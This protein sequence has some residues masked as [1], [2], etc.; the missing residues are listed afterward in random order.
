MPP[1]L[2]SFIP[3][4]IRWRI[5]ALIDRPELCLATARCLEKEPGIHSAEVS[6]I[7]GSVLIH[8]DHGLSAADFTAL[9][10]SA[11]R[12]AALE[13]ATTTSPTI[14]RRPLG[15]LPGESSLAALLTSTPELRTLTTTAIS[16]AFINRLFE[17]APPAMIGVAVDIVTRGPNSFI[18]KLGFKTIGRQLT[19]LGLVGAVVWTIDALF[20]YANSVTTND[21]SY[22]VQQD[23]RVALY[24]HLQT[25]DI[26]TIEKK[27]VS[28]WIGLLENDVNKVG[29]FIEQ[30]IGPV[31][32]MITNG[33]FVA[34]SLLTLSP[35]VAAVHIAVGGAVYL[36]S[37]RML[38]EIRRRQI[39]TN[40]REERLSA[41]L[42][43]DVAGITTIVNFGQQEHEAARVEQ[44]GRELG[45]SAHHSDS[46]SA[47]YVPAIQ[48]AV[49]AGFL[50]TLVYG[51]V[52]AS[53]EEMT[54]GAY[55]SLG[56]QSLRLL[57][58]LGYLG[59]AIERY[60][61]AKVSMDRILRL[62]NRTPRITGGDE[63]GDV[64][65]DIVF[66]NV[67]FAYEPD[68]PVLRGLS[69]T[70]PAGK[71]TGI[72]GLTGA[73]K[74]T[75]LKLLLRHYEHQSGS[76]VL[77]GVNVRDWSLDELH[78]LIATVP[79][80]TFLFAGTIRENIAY[81]KPDAPLEDVIAAARAA[82][83]HGFIEELPEGYETQVGENGL[84][85]SG[86]QQQRLSIARA[87]L[88]KR[89]V[90]LFDEAT[91]AVDYETE[92]SI[93]RSLQSVTAGRTTVVIAHRLSTIRNADLI[94]VLDAGQ[95]RE[96]GAHDQ[97]IA[98]NGIYAS[99]WRIQVGEVSKPKE[100]RR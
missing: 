89:P 35:V 96:Q 91:S 93:Q 66:D 28:D 100:M 61:R 49:G 72:V 80:Q 50:T 74:T 44:A 67:S 83:A 47:A 9:L 27:Q 45:A 7:T 62:L 41:L 21:L 82:E 95:V 10:G 85:L 64:A 58:A 4:R 73:G 14:A 22:A 81:A 5:P 87:I 76:I 46:A 31:V 20:G 65:G 33:L 32:T 77:G 26:S 53:R 57:S 79:Q 71:T 17:A 59:V 86:G 56:F 68:R 99:L 51:G 60:Q 90:L 69:M 92:A 42:H 98:A 16:V 88:A 43:G 54:V 30:G 52:A 84:K 8:G 15:V 38:Q 12:A 39:A 78:H 75:V 6:A 48:M 34:G 2:R 11:L 94:Y 70:F 36:I 37:T 1:Q 18:G 23:L 40:D 25:L 24:R 29:R 19:V 13:K 3:G 55:N 63:S 97:L